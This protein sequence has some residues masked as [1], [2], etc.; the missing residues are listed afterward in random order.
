MKGRGQYYV[1]KHSKE[2]EIIRLGSL[3]QGVFILF[4]KLFAYIEEKI[5]FLYN[6]KLLPPVLVAVFKVR[7]GTQSH[8]KDHPNS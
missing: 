5:D 2:A 1:W 4:D 6:F 8:Q 3:F 7:L